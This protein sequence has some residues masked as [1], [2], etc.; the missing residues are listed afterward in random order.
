MYKQY[1]KMKKKKKFRTPVNFI[2][3]LPGLAARCLCGGCK[4]RASGRLQP[5]SY[6]NASFRQ[7]SWLSDAV[8]Q[9]VQSWA[10]EAPVSSVIIL[11]ISIISPRFPALK[12]VQLKKLKKCTLSLYNISVSQKNPDDEKFPKKFC[13]NPR[14]PHTNPP[15]NGARRRENYVKWSKNQKIPHAFAMKKI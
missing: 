14:Y 13:I 1:F 10:S 6:I 5:T 12:L 4:S 11:S 2:V 7:Y 8:G 9:R 3:E 15:K